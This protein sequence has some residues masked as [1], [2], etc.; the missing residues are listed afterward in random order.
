LLKNKVVNLRLLADEA[1]LDG[2]HLLHKLHVKGLLLLEALVK[3]LLL[4]L[5]LF[6][7]V[8][9]CLFLSLVPLVFCLL[10]F[11]Q[12]VMESLVIILVESLL[13]LFDL[14]TP[15]DSALLTDSFLVENDLCAQSTYS[16]HGSLPLNLLPLHVWIRRMSQ[17]APR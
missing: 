9:L 6:E 15:H 3:S 14:Q 17:C 5:L 4:L 16:W 1:F 10:L 12:D 13:I 11:I 7:P 2:P 8:K